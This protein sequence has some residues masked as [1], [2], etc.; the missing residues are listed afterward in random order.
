MP[1]TVLIRGESGT[2]EGKLV[3]NAI[4]FNSGRSKGPLVK[5]NCASIPETL[6]ESELFGHEKGAF[7]NAAFRRIG[8]F[9][10]AS[11]W[12]ALLSDMTLVN[13]LPP[14][15]RSCFRGAI[16]E[17]TIERLGNGNAP[18]SVNI[19]LLATDFTQSG[20]SR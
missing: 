18:I 10:E 16:K 12:D 3:V 17:Q 8:R 11:G 1:C 6:L 4:H 2:G 15:N 13:W 5:V 14:S 9:E 7:T 20:A 19:R